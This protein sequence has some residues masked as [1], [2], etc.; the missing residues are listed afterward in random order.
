M[1]VYIRTKFQDSGMILT[2]LDGVGR[3]GG[4]YYA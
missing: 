1:D 4:L 2:N 3:G